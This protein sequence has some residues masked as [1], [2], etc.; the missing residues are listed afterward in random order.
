MEQEIVDRKIQAQALLGKL[1]LFVHK[2]QG[3]RP[4]KVV[5]VTSDGMVVLEGWGAEFA[6]HL[7]VEVR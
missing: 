4:A 7:F 3:I 2:P 6:P 1:V 5:E